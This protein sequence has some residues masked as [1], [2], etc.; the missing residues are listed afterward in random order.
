MLVRIINS[1]KPGL[2]KPPEFRSAH[3][4]GEAGMAIKALVSQWERWS[5]L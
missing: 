2:G 4:G 5:M 3:C 1:S